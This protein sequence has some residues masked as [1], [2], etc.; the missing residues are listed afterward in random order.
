MH[1]IS[2]STV[3]N[4]VL[5]SFN[6]I[7]EEGDYVPSRNG[8]CTSIFDTTFEVTNPRSRH[9]NLVGRKSN[10]FALIAETFWVMAGED[11]VKPYLN[12]FLPRAPDYS[13]DGQTWHGAYGPR[14]YRYNQ[15]IDAL[16]SF[17]TDGINTR[18]SFVTISDPMLDN[19]DNIQDTYGLDHKAKD[20]PCN[21]EIHFYVEKGKFCA[22]TIQRSG[23]MIFG[24]GSI[25]PF[26]FSFLHELMYNEVKAGYPEIELGPYRWHVTNAHLYDF[27]KSQ[28]VEAVSKTAN[29]ANSLD[30]NSTPLIGPKIKDW[31]EF[32]SELVAF[33]TDA[34]TIDEDNKER[35]LDCLIAHLGHT[36]LAYEVPLEDNLMWTYAQL[37]AHY[38]A[39][40]RGY[41][42]KAEMDISQCDDEFQRAVMESSFLKFDILFTV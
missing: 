34:I 22:K 36:F 38:I 9:L 25:N 12:F 31:Q 23:D 8:G 1:L 18:R 42:L 7:L 37:V 41:Q 39:N 4:L 33:Y 24:T 28:A 26:E 27:S 6:T 14:M 17:E 11:K 16:S 15:F 32:F 2:G 20:I 13:D 35:V 5:Q 21:R 40:K 30:Q 19:Q 3:S 10:I 29:Y